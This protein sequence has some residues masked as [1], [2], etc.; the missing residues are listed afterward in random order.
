M[1]SEA[2]GE[3]PSRILAVSHGYG[4]DLSKWQHSQNQWNWESGCPQYLQLIVWAFLL[5]V[6]ASA[7]K[8]VPL[9]T[10]RRRP[11][12]LGAILDVFS[13]VNEDPFHA[14]E[15]F[16][17]TYTAFYTALDKALPPLEKSLMDLSV[18]AMDEV[19]GLSFMVKNPAIAQPTPSYGMQPF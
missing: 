5:R 9:S 16:A 10:L 11:N 2:F 7:V 14:L 1:I 12:L 8:N 3:S 15:C 18:A 6:C 17:F 19:K 13:K 4:R